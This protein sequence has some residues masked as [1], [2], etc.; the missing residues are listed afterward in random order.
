MMREQP[1]IGSE[2]EIEFRYHQRYTKQRFNVIL[3]LIVRRER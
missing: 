1:E 3:T 2:C